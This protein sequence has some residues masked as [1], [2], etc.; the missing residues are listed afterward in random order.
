M[1]PYQTKFFEYRRHRR[2][3]VTGGPHAPVLDD[4]ISG[5]IAVAAA[6]AVDR[7]IP[8]IQALLLF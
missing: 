5:T 2:S 6:R 7:R 4:A 3:V 8:F 1:M